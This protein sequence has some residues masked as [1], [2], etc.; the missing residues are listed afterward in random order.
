[1]PLKSVKEYGCNKSTRLR[2]GTRKGHAHIHESNRIAR[3]HS[4]HK[5]R[6]HTMM[7]QVPSCQHSHLHVTAIFTQEIEAEMSSRVLD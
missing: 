6:Q 7:T 5:T 3:R 2:G 4:N 1:M